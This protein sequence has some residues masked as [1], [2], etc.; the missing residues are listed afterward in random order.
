MA[1]LKKDMNYFDMFVKGV[2]YSLD[3]AILLKDLLDNDSLSE[4]KI[5]QIKKIEQEADVHSHEVFKQLNV[6]FITPID[7]EDIYSIIKET[8]DITDSIEAVS[9]KMWMMSVNEITPAMKLMGQ[10][11]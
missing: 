5:Q 9:N 4:E 2:Q 3:A 11:I 6:A 1:L 10:Y 7:R 8:D